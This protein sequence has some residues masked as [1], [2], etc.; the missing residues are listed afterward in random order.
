MQAIPQKALLLVTA[1][2]VGTKLALR[3]TP[4]SKYMR[5][6]TNYDVEELNYS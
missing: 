5:H 1:L 4:I 3:K 2:T 6:E